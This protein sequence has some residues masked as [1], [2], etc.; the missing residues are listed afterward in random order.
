MNLGLM[1]NNVSYSCRVDCPILNLV[2]PKPCP[3]SPPVRT[4]L[5]IHSVACLFVPHIYYHFF[6]ATGGATLLDSWQ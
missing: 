5:S 4:V 6:Q 1:V 3:S 2:I